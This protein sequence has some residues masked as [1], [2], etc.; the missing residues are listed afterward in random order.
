MIELTYGGTFDAKASDTIR[1]RVI[2]VADGGDSMMIVTSNEAC[3]M[4]AALL[5]AAD[6][7]DNGQAE[8]PQ[9]DGHG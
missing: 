9:N 3:A 2:V 7:A 1:G 4:A 5:M 6:K 8:E